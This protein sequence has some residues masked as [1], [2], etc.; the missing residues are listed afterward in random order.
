MSFQRIL[1]PTDFSERAAVATACACELA[2]RL[3]AELH[4]LH[5]LE[6]H[7]TATPQ[8]ELG[9]VLPAKVHE[10]K[11]AAEAKL[12]AVLD[13]EW[14]QR[15]T[16]VKAVAEGAPVHAIVRYAQQ[17]QIDLIV[18]STHGRTGLAHVLLGSVAESVLRQ[19]PCPVLT[20]RPTPAVTSA[21]K[22]AHP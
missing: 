6:A 10:S 15:H 18:M 19:A 3:G 7:A 8:F 9:V 13:P 14:S 17:H 4:L 1:L 5:V 20:V 2:E 12:D 16:V 21:K 11:V 22:G